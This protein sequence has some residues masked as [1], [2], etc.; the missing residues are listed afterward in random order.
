MRCGAIDCTIPHG[1]G[2]AGLDWNLGYRPYETWWNWAA[3]GGFSTDGTRVGFN[4]TAHRPWD[5]AQ[6]H[7]QSD[8]TDCAVWVGGRCI[9]LDRVEFDYT[10]R[11]ILQP[12]RIHDADGIVDLEFSPAGKRADDV[13]FGIVVSQ[14]QQPYGTFRGRLA[15]KE[16]ADVFGVTEQHFAKW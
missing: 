1:E 10:P 12:W 14:F 7:E 16:I 8:A 5:D 15:D 9:K 4:L 2:H 3:G 6:E 13:N 11:A